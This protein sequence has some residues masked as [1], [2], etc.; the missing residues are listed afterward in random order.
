M[1]RFRAYLEI[2]R[3]DTGGDLT[4]PVGVY[5]PMAKEHV[6]QRL[7]ELKELDAELLMQ[8]ALLVL[9]KEI[10]EEHS[11]Q[12]FKV[13]AGLADDLQGSWTNRCTTDYGSKFRIGALVGRGFCTPVFWSSET[14]DGPM[15]GRRTLEYCYRT[16][17]WLTSP[18]PETL[19]EH[20]LQE[21]FVAEKTKDLQ[22][23]LSRD[24]KTLDLFYQEHKKST[25][26]ALILCFLYG[27]EAVQNLG[28]KTFGIR[29]EMA[30]FK[31]ARGR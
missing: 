1:D 8:D 31:Y 11:K 10:E 27:D 19:E 30:G 6:L 25:D 29:E 15:I 26:H 5:N 16:L 24:F 23:E 17:Y 4:F 14:F 7:L 21:K 18:K 22:T 20:I 2:L 28:Q 12:D 3:G 13:A 9:N